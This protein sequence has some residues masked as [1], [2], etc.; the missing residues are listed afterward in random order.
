[1]FYT[2]IEFD[3]HHF[4]PHEICEADN[5]RRGIVDD[6]EKRLEPHMFVGERNRFD[7]NQGEIGDC[8]FLSP[9]SMLAENKHFMDLVI[10]R[11]QSFSS[12]YHGIFRFRFYRFGDWVE[13][14][15]DDRLP[16]RNGKLIYLRS[17]EPNEFWSALF[18]KAYAKFYGSYAA[19]E[20]GV[21]NDAAVDFTGGIPELIN[22]D[23]N[24]TEEESD[25]LFHV[26]ETVSANGAMLSTALGNNLR[27][28]AT[29][30]GLQSSHA[31]SMTA[32]VDVSRWFS[33]EKLQLI[34]LRNPHGDGGEWRGDWSDD[35]PLWSKVSSSTKKNIGLESSDD[36]EFYISFQD[37]VKYFGRVQILHLTPM[38][39]Q[40][41]ERRMNRSFTMITIPGRWERGV[42]DGGTRNFAANPQFRMQ[43]INKNDRSQTCNLVI[44]LT[45]KLPSRKTEKNI[46]FRLYKVGEEQKKD[47]L[48]GPQFIDNGLNMVSDSGAFINS[49]EVQ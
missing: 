29:Y 9:L 3:K 2:I 18:E 34:R 42:T 48:L 4:R 11:G 30:K 5:E 21:S 10:P 25:A 12:N 47:K 27:Y 41:N 17:G 14:V 39:M 31:Y 43:I 35:S 44:S 6:E 19:I 46:G 13:I 16:T 37:F 32:V 20:G 36:G 1:M 28:E 8:W 49:R 24:M 7:I 15:I 45:Q 26:L 22:I 23:H 40:M 33:S 38:R